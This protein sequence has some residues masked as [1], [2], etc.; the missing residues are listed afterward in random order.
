MWAI[1][2]KK[3][4]LTMSHIAV[5]WHV[6]SLLLLLACGAVSDALDAGAGVALP[7]TRAQHCGAKGAFAWSGGRSVNHGG[8]GE[9]LRLRGGHASGYSLGVRDS[10]MIAHS[11]EV[12]AC[13]CVFLCFVFGPWTYTV[14]CKRKL[15]WTQLQFDSSPPRDGIMSCI[16]KLSA[17]FFLE[18][19]M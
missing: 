7:A 10:I 3:T 12:C 18:V 9:M 5:I 14:L 15:L 16:S 17:T 6:T 11:F 4:S 1:P 8:G 13:L 2:A 19:C